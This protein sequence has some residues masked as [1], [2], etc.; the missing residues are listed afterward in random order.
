VAQS[1]RI[2]WIASLFVA[3]ACCGT[4]VADTAA[5][6]NPTPQTAAAPQPTTATPQ[7]ATAA[8]QPPAQ[9]AVTPQQVA[10]T[11]LKMTQDGDY[12]DF[13]KQLA[14]SCQ[15]DD[16]PVAA[17]MA[18]KDAGKKCPDR[19]PREEWSLLMRGHVIKKN[20]MT[21]LVIRHTS[22]FDSCKLPSKILR[23]VGDPRTTNGVYTV[24]PTHYVWVELTDPEFGT[25]QFL[26]LAI[27]RIDDNGWQI[28]GG[29]CVVKRP[30]LSL[31]KKY[32]DSTAKR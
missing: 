10:Q 19:I 23:L 9:P 5:T 31:L 24:K 25:K 14:P 6:N 2:M 28:V 15:P 30:F 7:P 16:K 29:S 4:A 22:E 1:Q 8:P 13:I 12:A 32:C 17:G 27:V 18:C 3:V 21:K 20:V 26:P 11:L